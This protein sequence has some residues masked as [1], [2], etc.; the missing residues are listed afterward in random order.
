[1]DNLNLLNK[2]NKFKINGDG[3]NSVALPD[4][5]HHLATRQ[6]HRARCTCLPRPAPQPALPRL[7]STRHA[8]YS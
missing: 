1:M 8:D 7:R 5:S 3:F 4:P 6:Q 2:P